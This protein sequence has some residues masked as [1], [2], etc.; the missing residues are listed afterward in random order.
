MLRA[1]VLSVCF[2]ACIALEA[3]AST[4]ATVPDANIYQKKRLDKTVKLINV[5]KIARQLFGPK[6]AAPVPDTIATVGDAQARLYW[7]NKWTWSSADHFFDRDLSSGLSGGPM[8]SIGVPVV[9]PNLSVELR[10]STL[11]YALPEHARRTP[12]PDEFMRDRDN[13]MS[14]EGG[15]YLNFSFD[16]R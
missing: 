2:C 6:N 5:R 8:V 16:G 11:E 10:Y 13:H 9:G 1:R 4:K 7:R 12:T 3:C 14:F 15:L